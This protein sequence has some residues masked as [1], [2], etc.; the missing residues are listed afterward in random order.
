M[1]GHQSRLVIGLPCPPPVTGHLL[2]LSD[3]SFLLL[4]PRYL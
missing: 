3:M 2:A 1:S 4:F